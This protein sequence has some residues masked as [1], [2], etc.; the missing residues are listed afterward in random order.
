MCELVKYCIVPYILVYCMTFEDQNIHPK[1][2][3]SFI[4]RDMFLGLL[5]LPCSEG[6]PELLRS[7]NSIVG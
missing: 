3:G 2:Q 4:T 6:Y 7:V 1:N 5:I